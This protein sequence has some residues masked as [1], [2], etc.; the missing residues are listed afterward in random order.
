MEGI[1]ESSNAQLNA[2][3][4]ER[5]ELLKDI[6]VHLY[7]DENTKLKDLVAMMKARYQFYA[8]LVPFPSN[9]I[10]PCVDMDFKTLT[11]LILIVKVSTKHSLKG[12]K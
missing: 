6:M 3:Y 10:L 9:R 12:G 4:A 7:I 2:P 8:S 5:W 1:A 11:W